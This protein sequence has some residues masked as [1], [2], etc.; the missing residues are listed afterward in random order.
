MVKLVR[1]AFEEKKV[2]I[3]Y[4]NNEINFKYDHNL[5]YLQEKEGCHLANKLR[6][7]NIFYFKLKIQLVT[8]ILSQSVADDLTFYKN[9][10]KLEE[11]KNV[12]PTIKLIELFIVTLR[13][14]I[15]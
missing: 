11:F 10:L 15:Y 3:D 12:G 2:F 13:L 8:Q 6:K 14:L 1:N 9:T 5:C 7:N 4:Q